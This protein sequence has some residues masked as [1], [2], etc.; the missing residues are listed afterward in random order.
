MDVTHRADALIARR[1]R[2][3]LIGRIALPIAFLTAW[4][5]AV[6]RGTLDGFYVSKPSEIVDFLQA[7][8]TQSA[9][10]GHLWVTMQETIVGLALATL[11][12]ILAALLFTRV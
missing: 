2:L 12:G 11:L 1:R 4:Q 10:W 9:T 3:V 7:S 5:V 8:L 6:D